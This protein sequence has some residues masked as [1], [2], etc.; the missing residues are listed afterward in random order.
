MRRLAL[1]ICLLLIGPSTNAHTTPRQTPRAWSDAQL[2]EAIQR[3]ATD[4]DHPLP[5]RRADP[6]ALLPRLTRFQRQTPGTSQRYRQISF[7]LAYLGVD[8]RCNVQRLIHPVELW[9]HGRYSE[10]AIYERD[11]SDPLS[12]IVAYLVRLYRRHRDPQLL[13]ILFAWR[14]DGHWAEE[15][16]VEKVRLLTVYPSAVLRAVRPSRSRTEIATDA[17]AT[18]V[19]ADDSEYRR[20]VRQ[21]QRASH[22]SSPTERRFVR[23]FLRRL[24]AR[25]RVY[26]R[27]RNVRGADLAGANLYGTDMSGLDLRGADLRSAYLGHADLSGA[28]LRR[29]DL[30][31]ARYDRH[32]LWPRGFDPRRRG[33]IRVKDE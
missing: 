5:F 17:L 16:D 8:Y 21:I 11:N 33:A 30:R 28:R 22:R 12:E 3:F 18:E 31:G 4:G 32:T 20:A 2:K 1:L 19:G 29:S 14:L 23:Q 9:N 25:R 7:V 24:D 15:L 26:E 27:V 10:L 6:S 13:R